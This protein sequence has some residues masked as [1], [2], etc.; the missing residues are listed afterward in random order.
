MKIQFE[1]DLDFQLDAIDAVCNLFVGQEKGNSSFSVRAP[2]R[3]NS[4]SFAS[5]ESDLGAGNQLSLSSSDLL[6]NLQRVQLRSGLSPSPVLDS[7][8]FTVEMETGTGKTY[9]YLRTILELNK[10]FGFSKF[11]IVVPSVAI[12]EGVYKTLEMTRA[13]FR[14]LYSGVPYSYFLYDSSRMNDVYAFAL[15]GEVQI[16][17]T[18][19]GAINKKEIN[20]LYREDEA[21]TK[22]IDVI[23]STAPILIV[24]EPQSVDGGLRGAG[25][26]AIDG[27][28]ALATLRYSAIHANKHHMI[29]RLNA[30]DAYE[31]G[32]VKQVEVAAA[33]LDLGH[34]TPFVR[35]LRVRQTAGTVSAE[36]E[37]DVQTESGSARRVRRWVNDG[38][39]LERLTGRSIY[40][41]H[42]VGEIGLSGEQPYFE[43]R[44]PGTE[45]YLA[46]GEA[47]GNVDP[48]VVQRQMIRR[49]IKE[50]L[51]K[52][53]RLAPL[54]IKVLSLFFIDKVERYRYY[55]E[56]GLPVRGP[57]AEIFEEEYRRL[58][59]N[60]AYQSLLHAVDS[61]HAASDAHD[62]YFS[63]D[64]AGGWTETAL[65]GQGA[66]AERGYNLIMKEKERLLSFDTPLRFIFSHSAL[67]EGWDNP[68]IF[69]IC[70]LRD[71]N[72]E[73]ARRQTIGRGLRLCVDQSGQRVRD[74]QVN[75]LTV[76]ANEA[77]E[78]FALALQTEIERD[79]GI[80]FGIVEP[81]SFV[82]VT[83][84]SD[85]DD[86]T[87]L[88]VEG[89]LEVWNHLVDIGYID[90]TGAVCAPL[91]L[92]LEVGAFELTDELAPFAKQIE[93]VLRRIV[94]KVIV[95]NADEARPVPIRDDIFLSEDFVALWDRVKS[96]TVYRLQFDND[97]LIRRSSENLRLAPA[98]RKNRIRWAKAT[99]D[100]TPSG[101]SAI[102]QNQT[103]A[104]VLEEAPRGLPDLLTELQDRTQ[105]TRR[106]IAKILIES[107]RLPEFREEPEQFIVMAAE[108]IN[109][110]K[111]LAVVDGI[112]YERSS[113]N[114][115]FAQDL[116][117]TRELRGYVKN[118]VL[119]AKRSVYE[120]VLVDSAVERRFAE[121][122]ESDEDIA[123]FVKLPR[124]FRIPTPL[125]TYNPDW[126]MVS[127][128][129]S[130][131]KL[132]FVVETKGTVFI[133]DLRDSEAAKIYCGKAHFRSFSETDNPASYLVATSLEDVSARQ[134]TES[135]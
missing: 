20:N 124:W 62:G 47:R 87:Y 31:K 26:Q 73:V 24:D 114:E 126:A 80:R 32:L 15:S 52:E 72:S 104:V 21:G 3:S 46:P 38:V 134:T 17:I 129:D 59:K 98:V 68:N 64:R 56:N 22:P 8:D 13:H 54:G 90:G 50:H 28:A 65:N 127:N 30:V 120:D 11:V 128:T 74:D 23:R 101:V 6:D 57:Y 88:G 58:S 100:V 105:L 103:A 118:L 9:V 96:R 76:I 51:D 27:M 93:A 40:A 110:T 48:L 37:L 14:A 79:T 86:P 122:L 42:S 123:A 41:G 106:S 69:Q 130:G 66:D 125:G 5:T 91:R 71:I 133:N 34:G 112:Q 97:E 61:I 81:T 109:K 29:Y 12:K 115:A 43:L 92:A 82:A 89:S 44:S 99:L 132:F 16:M 63:I 78:E 53:M 85:G 84:D 117:R 77:Y 60:P 108:V 113:S 33:T 131:E 25:K 35:F 94:T 116:L 95:R 10:R 49:T 39:D 83:L 121:E 119:D 19:V 67:R 36:V 55:D 102:P 18:T 7:R 4:E 107:K 111:R 75:V 2:S 1:D 135:N 70:S 45:E